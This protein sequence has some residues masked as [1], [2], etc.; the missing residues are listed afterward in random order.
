MANALV[1]SIGGVLSAFL[2]GT[3]SDCIRRR[4]SLRRR[5]IVPAVGSLLAVPAMIGVLY[6]PS[7]YGSMA[8][9]FIEYGEGFP[10]VYTTDWSWLLMPSLH[11][12][13]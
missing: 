12:V 13:C 6:V 7:F 10:Y 4:C 11:S 1:I 5:A 2:G 8:C 3:I 9:L